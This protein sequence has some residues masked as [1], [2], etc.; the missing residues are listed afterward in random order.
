LASPALQ[1]AMANYVVQAHM[2]FSIL[3]SV[4][5]LRLCAQILPML[6]NGTTELTAFLNAS[7]LHTSD[8]M[9]MALLAHDAASL[10]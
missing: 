4:C 2:Y 1:H 5:N 6:S 9:F 10:K 7:K 8:I 3:N